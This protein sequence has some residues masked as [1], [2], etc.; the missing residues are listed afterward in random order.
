MLPDSEPLFFHFRGSRWDNKCILTSVS[1]QKCKEPG[2]RKTFLYG[3]LRKKLEVGGNLWVTNPTGAR[4]SRLEIYFSKWHITF[5]WA[6]SVFTSCMQ[7]LTSVFEP[8]FIY[9]Q[10]RRKVPVSTFVGKAWERPSPARWLVQSASVKAHPG[11]VWGCPHWLDIWSYQKQ[12][13]KDNPRHE[14][15]GWTNGF[16]RTAGHPPMLSAYWG[17]PHIPKDLCRDSINPSRLSFCI[18]HAVVLLFIHTFVFPPKM[19]EK[20]GKPCVL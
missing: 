16:P 10:N 6:W 2:I 7:R 12:V 19:G 9:L 5:S 3:I 1:K 14:E 20:E 13:F 17:P 8:Q 18:C 11:F 4:S 15:Q